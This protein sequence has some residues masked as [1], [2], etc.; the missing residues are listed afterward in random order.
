MEQ[1][2]AEAQANLFHHLAHL[3]RASCSLL[4]TLQLTTVIL[5][6]AAH[7][8]VDAPGE[9]IGHLTAWNELTRK[10]RLRS[11]SEYMTPSIA[12]VRGFVPNH[13]YI[14][15]GKFNPTNIYNIVWIDYDIGNDWKVLYWQRAFLNLATEIPGP[16]VNLFIRTPRFAL[17]KTNFYQSATTDGTWDFYIQP[18]IQGFSQET[19]LLKRPIE[20]GFR[21][22][23]S[24]KPP[25]QSWSLGLVSELTLTTDPLASFYGWFMP[26]ASYEFN[27]T[28]STQHYFAVNFQQLRGSGTRSLAWD[29]PM[30]YTQQGVGINVSKTLWMAVFLNTYLLTPPTLKTTWV[31]VWFAF[32]FL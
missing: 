12:G 6:S 7:A 3:L 9:P 15:R 31:S 10:F 23:T 11:F 14:N 27:D 16:Q 4:L 26:W 5:I 8:D 28:F 24:Y 2:R 21:T 19:A 13:A 32:T 30:P 25:D 20:A 18:G 1:S 22:S 17:R 29:A